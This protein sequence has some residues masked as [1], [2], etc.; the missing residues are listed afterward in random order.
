MIHRKSFW[1]AIGGL[2][3]AATLAITLAAPSMAAP[4]TT[5]DV[6]SDCA[7]LATT[8]YSSL[9][10]D[11]LHDAQALAQQYYGY[12]QA[13]ASEMVSQLAATYLAVK[14]ADVAIVFNPGAGVGDPMSQIPGWTSILMGLQSALKASGHSVALVDYQRTAHGLYGVVTEMMGL[15]C[16]CRRPKPTSWRRAST[17]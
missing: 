6:N 16:G 17:S 13:K 12:D 5:C 3:L 10:P 9:P 11:V 15:D 1:L 14:D 4:G 8:D 2:L 7:P